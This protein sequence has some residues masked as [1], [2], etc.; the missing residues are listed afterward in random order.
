MSRP[1]VSE[2]DRIKGYVA[3]CDLVGLRQIRELIDFAM[4]REGVEPPLV[5]RATHRRAKADAQ[6]PLV[7]GEAQ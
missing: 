6:I 4:M 7:K 5:K 3:K 2:Y 1:K